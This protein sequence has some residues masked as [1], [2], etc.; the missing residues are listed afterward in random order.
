MY[1]LGVRLLSPLRTLP[2]EY[3]RRFLTP[4]HRSIIR[5][6]FNQTLM[7]VERLPLKVLVATHAMQSDPRS[8]AEEIRARFHSDSLLLHMTPQEVVKALDAINGI[9]QQIARRNG[10]GVADVREA[11]P[12]D[13][14]HW[15]DATHFSAQGS[16]LAAKE[17]A[18][19]ILKIVSRDSL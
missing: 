2:K 9:I 11:V 19:A 1:R 15:G 6:A 18:R 12:A 16:H 4:F 17:I 13:P 14:R 10:L 7:A 5:D 8:T 3:Q